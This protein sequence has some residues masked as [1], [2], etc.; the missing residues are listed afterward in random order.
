MEQGKVD[1]P[2]SCPMRARSSFSSSD[3][4]ETRSAK[5]QFAVVVRNEVVV[6]G[7]GRLPQRD[8]LFQ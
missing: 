5:I 1:I 4:D 6:G 2:A 8:F 3:I 7:N